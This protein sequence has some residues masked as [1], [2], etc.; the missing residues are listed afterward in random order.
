L[1]FKFHELVKLVESVR[2]SLSRV[3]KQRNN[4]NNNNNSDGTTNSSLIDEKQWKSSIDRGLADVSSVRDATVTHFCTRRQFARQVDLVGVVNRRG[5]MSNLCLSCDTDAKGDRQTA[6]CLLRLQSLAPSRTLSTLGDWLLYDRT[7]NDKQAA[8]V[9]YGYSPYADNTIVNNDDSDDDDNDVDNEMIDVF[10]TLPT[11]FSTRHS[12]RNAWLNLLIEKPMPTH[13]DLMQLAQRFRIVGGQI[14]IVCSTGNQ[15]DQLWQKLQQSKELQRA[16][17]STV[18][19]DRNG[20]SKTHQIGVF[21]QDCAQIGAT[22]DRLASL[23]GIDRQQLSKEFKHDVY[24]LL[25]IDLPNRWNL[26]VYCDP[27]SQ[28]RDSC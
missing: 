12:L 21:V 4:N 6:Q 22:L 9:S 16:V 24:S 19:I 27:N 25:A 14:R 8:K 20:W 11:S 1:F 15:V 13:N 28:S 10:P 5:W 23:S 18:P 7:L 26:P 17:V 3:S 2:D